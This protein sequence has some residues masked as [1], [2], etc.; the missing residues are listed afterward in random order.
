[1]IRMVYFDWCAL[2]V[3]L[4]M[5]GSIVIRRMTKGKLNRLFLCLIAIAIVMSIFEIGSVHM[6]EHQVHSKM[7]EYAAHNVYLI[8]RVY[9]LGIYN[10]YLVELTDN[11]HKAGKSP[12]FRMLMVIPLVA[13]VIGVMTNPWTGWFYILEDYTF[14]R[15]PLYVI[16]YLAAAFYGI[17]G[18][19]Y[20]LRYRRFLGGKRFISLLAVYPMLLLGAAIQYWHPQIHVEMFANAVGLLFIMMMIQRPEERLEITTGLNKIHAFAADMKL[21]FSNGKPMKVVMVNIA[22]YKA[23]REVIGYDDTQVLKHRI[24]EFL[25]QVDHKNHTNAEMYYLDGGR[26]S[27]VVDEKYFGF[28]ENLAEQINTFMKEELVIRDIGI[29][30]RTYVCIVDCPKDV[31]RFDALLNIENDLHKVDYTGEVMHCNTLLANKQF[32]ILQKI[33]EIM[34]RALLNRGFEVYYQPIYSLKQHLFNSAEALLRLKDEEYGF[35]SPE[36]FIPAAE[37]SGAIRRIGAFVFEEVCRFI[38]SKEFK[39]LG[40]DYIEVNLSVIQCMQP[41]LAKEY[42]DIMNLYGVRPDQ[43]NLEITE[44][45]ASVSQK[46]MNAN[47]EEFTAAGIKFSLDDFGT[48]YSNMR[49]IATLPFAMVKLDKSFA[50]IDDN[51]KLQIVLNNT[52]NMIKDMDMKI[53]V[54]GI[55]TEKLV[56]LFEELQCEYIQGFYYSK[57]IPQNEFVEFINRARLA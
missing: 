16:F 30:M 34:E 22:N 20:I 40:L 7:L 41:G 10:F 28:V 48:G 57:P 23:L 42:L 36:I 37:H 44:T 15:Q 52:I 2:I 3:L 5:A 14:V 38:A 46:A 25:V 21:A 49:R 12:L 17:Y 19:I 11:W 29:S 51:P 26:F 47:I 13:V 31:N 27:L 53:V 4:L 50:E 33:D 54:E 1:M 39:N 32:D 56:K 8:L 18:W 45:A 6:E 35:I 24:G 9:M 43:I 55:E